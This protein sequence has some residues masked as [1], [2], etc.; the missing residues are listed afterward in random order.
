MRDELSMRRLVA[1]V[2]G[3]V[4]IFHFSFVIFLLP[5]PELIIVGD[6]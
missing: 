5:S 3:I 2:P 6:Q 4:F 1:V